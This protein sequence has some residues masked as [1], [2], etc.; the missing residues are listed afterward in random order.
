V[1]TRKKK[2]PDEGHV[3]AGLVVAKATDESPAIPG[4]LQESQQLSVEFLKIELQAALTFTRVAEY[5]ADPLH[6]EQGR[7]NAAEA[8]NIIQKPLPKVQ[9]CEQDKRWIECKLNELEQV[10]ERLWKRLD[11]AGD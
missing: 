10:L 6:I 5:S 4:V 9:P 2:P 1:P 3:I 8:Y 7:R 11:K